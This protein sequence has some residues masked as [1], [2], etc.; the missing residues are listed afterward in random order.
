MNKPKVT[1]PQKA[2]YSVYVVKLDA[3]KLFQK[4]RCPS[5]ETKC[6]YVGQT[7]KSPEERLK[8]HK[9]GIRAARV[10]RDYGVRLQPGITREIGPFQT[11]RE[12]LRAE[13]RLSNRLKARR[14]YR[15]WG[16][17]GR[18]LMAGSRARRRSD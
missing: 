13:R 18:P 6:V 5:P 12:A 10:V 11:E 17:Q 4:G 7:S 15:V 2:K 3:A 1:P 8:Q 14:G 16:G 9:A